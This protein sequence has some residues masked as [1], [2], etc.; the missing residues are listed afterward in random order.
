MF[1]MLGAVITFNCLCAYIKLGV[2]YTPMRQTQKNQASCYLLYINQKDKKNHT[3]N[4][5]QSP[6]PEFS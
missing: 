6:T 1:K 4:K 5:R 3:K 2:E